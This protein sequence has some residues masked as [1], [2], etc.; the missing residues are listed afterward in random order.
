MIGLLTS[1]S[2]KI[3]LLLLLLL[4]LLVIISKF[5]VQKQP[6]YCNVL[7]GR[8]DVGLIN[9]KNNHNNN[10]KSNHNHNNNSH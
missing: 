1:T 9:H 10:N 2:I 8:T 6:I 7:H 4:L 3:L 5:V